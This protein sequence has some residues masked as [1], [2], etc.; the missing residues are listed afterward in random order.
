MKSSK[1]VFQQDTN[2]LKK[3]WVGSTTQSNGVHFRTPLPLI[4]KRH[5]DL[6]GLQANSWQC[7]KDT[8]FIHNPLGTLSY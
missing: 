4:P 1:M 8:T 5:Q 6:N 2:Q 7:V 3:N